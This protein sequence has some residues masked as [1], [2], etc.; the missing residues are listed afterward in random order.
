MIS[1]VLKCLSAVG[2]NVYCLN[3]EETKTLF[4]LSA[5]CH[6]KLKVG[7][8]E[9]DLY[10]KKQTAI[11]VI[12]FQGYCVASARLQHSGQGQGWM[13]QLFRESDVADYAVWVQLC[14]GAKG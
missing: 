2:A 11:S 5:S 14:F 1:L 8:R 13:Q 3:H 4:C 7:C 6:D 9:Y 10:V 12:Q